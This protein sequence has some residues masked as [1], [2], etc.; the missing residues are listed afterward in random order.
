MTEPL[1]NH[2]TFR[3]WDTARDFTNGHVTFGATVIPHL[4]EGIGEFLAATGPRTFRQYQS[5][6]AVGVVPWLTHPEIV[7]RLSR[8]DAA[9]I[10][11][12][13][14]AHELSEARELQT[15]AKPIPASWVGL[16]E[17]GHVD[18]NGR[19]PIIGPSSPMPGEEIS[20]S[21]SYGWL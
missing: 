21:S 9:C 8:M 16:E 3:Q 18:E 17:H 10:T 15:T 19:A 13:K 6:V 20:R 4:V 5:R 2:A 1:G 14:G 7:R 11:I 12:D